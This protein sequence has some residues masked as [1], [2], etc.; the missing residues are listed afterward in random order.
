MSHPNLGNFLEGFPEYMLPA[1]Y[2]FSW[3]VYVK[4][5]KLTSLLIGCTK[6]C[7]FWC[8]TMSQVSICLVSVSNL[9]S[10]GNSGLISCQTQQCNSHSHWIDTALKKYATSTQS[11]VAW[12]NW[13][14]GWKSEEQSM[15]S[16][17]LSH[18]PPA[19]HYLQ[20]STHFPNK[21]QPPQLPTWWLNPIVS[22]Y[23]IS[24]PT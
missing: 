21:F 19:P 13:L 22:L 11:I 17:C 7:V 12:L 6:N 1:Q 5:V 4:K 18:Y 15:L 24:M 9:C 16:V 8:P 2:L 3:R 10:L 20:V 14:V 23:L